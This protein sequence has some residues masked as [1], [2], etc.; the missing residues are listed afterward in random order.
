[1]SNYPKNIKILYGQRSL[2]Q[3]EQ[4]Q[5]TLLLEQLAVKEDQAVREAAEKLAQ[6]IKNTQTVINQSVIT[7]YADPLDDPLVQLEESEPMLLLP[8]RLETRFA[9]SG[10]ELWVRVYPDEIAINN[11]D[12]ALSEPE[13][14]AGIYYWNFLWKQSTAVD[15]DA[16][17]KK[18]WSQ[19]V[20][21]F[22]ADRAR[23]LLLKTKP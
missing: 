1:M 10:T 11:H 17:K 9:A 4:D 18:A 14:K 22:G 12:K 13:K 19:I 8:L 5:Y 2:L 3:K 6:Q 23:W 21:H 15:F 16:Q 7:L 20:N